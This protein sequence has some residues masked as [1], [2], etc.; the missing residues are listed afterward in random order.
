MGLCILAGQVVTLGTIPPEA[1]TQDL[2]LD[3]EQTDFNELSGVAKRLE[4]RRESFRTEA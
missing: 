2:L 3:M 1:I 4:E